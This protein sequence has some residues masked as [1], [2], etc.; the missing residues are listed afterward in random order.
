MDFNNSMQ[1]LNKG[2]DL[3]WQ[4]Q[5]LIQDNV[6]NV[7]T[8]GYKAKY[9]SFEEEMKQSLEAH[10]NKSKSEFSNA[11]NNFDATIN[12]SQNESDRLDGNNVVIE[13]ENVEMARTQ[14]QYDFMVRQMSGQINMLRTVIDGRG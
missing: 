7:S 4:K 8:P 1:L 13:A 2:L 3:S 11:I 12:E 6:A 14:L 10:K 5:K 9:M